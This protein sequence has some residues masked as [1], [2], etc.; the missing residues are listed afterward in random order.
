MGGCV[1]LRASALEAC[2]AF[3]EVDCGADGPVS[4]R[5]SSLIGGE[6][7]SPIG[8]TRSG[9]PASLYA[10]RAMAPYTP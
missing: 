3:E 1:C 7:A 2:R 5:F 4:D 6:T 8:K 9:E 10:Y